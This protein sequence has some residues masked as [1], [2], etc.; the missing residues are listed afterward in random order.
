[1]KAVLQLMTLNFSDAGKRFLLATCLFAVGVCF[2]L[3]QTVLADNA[4]VRRS[5]FVLQIGLL[6]PM[7]VPWSLMHPRGALAAGWALMPWAKL[8]FVWSI[9]LTTTLVALVAAAL[10]VGGVGE[11]GA[12]AAFAS[13]FTLVSLM[14][15]PLLASA[16][17]VGRQVAL[18]MTG[19]LLYVVCVAWAM[20][21]GMPHVFD[22]A[23]AAAVW[24]AFG[25][26]VLAWILGGWW[27]VARARGAIRN[28]AQWAF[29]DFVDRVKSVYLLRQG[30]AATL[31]KARWNSAH[32]VAA[33]ALFLA[34]SLVAMVLQ[35]ANTDGYLAALA[36]VC[37]ATSIRALL[38]GQSTARHARAL[39]LV[40]GDRSAL[41]RECEAL[42]T[43]NIVAVA[44]VTSL[45]LWPCAALLDQSP[46]AFQLFNG[47]ALA[48]SM[49]LFFAYGGL[50][51][52]AL[53]ARVH[54]WVSGLVVAACS[55]WMFG[56]VFRTLTFAA[57]D[58]GESL[59]PLAV[60]TTVLALL[61]RGFASRAW[62]KVDWTFLP[63][64]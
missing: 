20:G 42:L 40:R 8:K 32:G 35:P 27:F 48:A 11:N 34:T 53:P 22:A 60:T 50:L 49:P 14:M 17:S 52:M 56:T 63:T 15:L 28:R 45:V 5:L 2:V 4:G 25:L 29:T 47:V 21:R 33:L 26:A 59:G 24:V 39:W 23:P 64:R 30:A 46:T 3:Q 41:F 1:V 37:V 10:F 31:L 18:S 9:A 54:W 6:V 7:M 12:L 51:L 36:L 16:T 38:L 61:C 57:R 58:A 55:L 43:R 19:L 44:V 62:R 13:T